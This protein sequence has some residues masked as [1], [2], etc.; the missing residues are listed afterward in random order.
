MQQDV[1][2][3]A[4]TLTWPAKGKA[5]A[6]LSSITISASEL[7]LPWI[8]T[9]ARVVWL[10]SLSPGAKAVV[11]T[12]L[13]LENCQDPSSCNFTIFPVISNSHSELSFGSVKCR[14]DKGIF[15]TLSKSLCSIHSQCIQPSG[16]FLYDLELWESRDNLV[17]WL[18][19]NCLKSYA[20]F[21]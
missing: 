3:M 1:L 5:S 19:Q 7:R 8:P 15:Q 17:G 16:H 6:S 10:N 14:M 11:T 21:S 13:P 20:H 18:N 4:Q 2:A 9:R 12:T